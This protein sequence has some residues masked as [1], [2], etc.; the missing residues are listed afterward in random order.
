MQHT[1]HC[2]DKWC[3]GC[4]EVSS[5]PL[6]YCSCGLINRIRK[7]MYKDHME[8]FRLGYAAALRDAVEAIEALRCDQ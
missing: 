5:S 4:E 2:R 7:S 3:Q 6:P 1:D 8:T